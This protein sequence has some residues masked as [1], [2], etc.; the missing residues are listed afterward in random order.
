MWLPRM[1]Q[2]A[3]RVSHRALG[4]ID[5]LVNNA[6]MVGGG[7]VEEK[8]LGLGQN[9]MSMFRRFSPLPGM[10]PSP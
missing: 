7:P 2:R 5:F 4:R 9:L 1:R 8:P 10:H 6:G 3:L